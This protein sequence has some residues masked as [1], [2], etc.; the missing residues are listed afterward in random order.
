M[1]DIHVEQAMTDPCG[2]LLTGEVTI[3]SVNNVVSC[4]HSKFR[5]VCSAHTPKERNLGRHLSCITD[6]IASIMNID[7]ENPL[8]LVPR[9]FWPKEPGYEARNH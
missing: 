8:S 5:A 3:T 7:S 9:I 4:N 6:N 1:H 2:L